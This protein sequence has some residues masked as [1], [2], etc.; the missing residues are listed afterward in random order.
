MNAL[1]K[2]SDKE[3]IPFLRTLG[4][5]T[6]NQ[7]FEWM[8][9]NSEFASALE[10]MYYH[11]D[12]N[13]VLSETEKRRFE[14]IQKRN[15]HQDNVLSQNE[16]DESISLIQ[17]QYPGICPGDVDALAEMKQDIEMQREK[18]NLLAKH[19]RIVKDLIKQKEGINEQLNLEITKLNAAQQQISHEEKSLAQE[20]I[21]LADEVE[22]M[23][24]AVIEVVGNTMDVYGNCGEK[25]TAPNFFTFGPFDQY[26]QLQELYLSHFDLYVS[27]KFD[28]KQNESKNDDNEVLSQAKNMERRLSEALSEYIDSKAELCGEQAKLE[29]VAN[30]NNPHSSQLSMNILEA[31]TAVQLL[32]QEE[33]IIN[34]Q[35][36]NAI[37]EFV[38]DRTRIVE[39]TALNAALAIRE[40]VS[41]DLAYLLDTTQ[42]ALVLDKVLYSAL[43]HELHNIEEFLLFAAQLKQYVLD[44]N[45]AVTSRIC[46]M[47]E[48][49]REQASCEQKL[50]HSDVL[51]TSLCTVLGIEPTTNVMILVKSYND[52]ERDIKEAKEGIEDGFRVREEKLKEIEQSIRPLVDYIWDGC[53]K[54]PSS[55]DKTVA[56][57][58]HQLEQEMSKTDARILA[59]SAKFNSIKNSDN[60]LRKLWQ[61]FLTDPSKLMSVIKG[62]Q[63]GKYT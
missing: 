44:E 48:I 9:N 5:D 63:S 30:Y 22:D 14:E 2:L 52:L 15:L 60:Q 47:N 55:T 37:K 17:S 18:L 42:H 49:C 12:Y 33:G 54:Q 57:L 45:D 13:N 20:C 32:E 25:D 6:R 24:S 51:L 3:F 61:W 41:N 16:V 36:E 21:R 38:E 27:K 39:E 53:T 10:W 40:E 19:E 34:L 1:D 43:R 56:A 8:L 62:V 23:T 26:K 58:A 28:L 7:S 29:L 11:L 50:E 59:A 4:V 46:S 35:I 31:Q